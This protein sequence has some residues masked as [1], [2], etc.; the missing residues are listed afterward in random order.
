MRTGRHTKVRHLSCN[1]P[2]TRWMCRRWNGVISM[3]QPQI[4]LRLLQC[5]AKTTI[6]N[7][8]Y[9]YIGSS[10]FPRESY[11]PAAVFSMAFFLSSRSF[12]RIALMLGGLSIPSSALNSST[13]RSICSSQ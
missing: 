4:G 1:L 3:L 8:H 13:S 9:K 10:R 5:T 6:F 7:L 2:H 11:G 12:F